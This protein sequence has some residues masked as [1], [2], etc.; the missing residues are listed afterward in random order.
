MLYSLF[1]T[2]HLTG[3]FATFG[4]VGFAGKTL[5]Q[6]HENSYRY[7]AILL[8][9][10]GAFE[11]LS[12]IALA[13]VSPEVTALSLCKNVALYLAMVFGVEGLLIARMK[14]TFPTRLAFSP[15]AL[16]LM[17]FMGAIGYGF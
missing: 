13:V 9:V 10:L 5:L 17:L 1:L 15:I 8:G 3:A 6:Q 12:G 7:Y 16:S 2:L 14:Q 11:I 4:V